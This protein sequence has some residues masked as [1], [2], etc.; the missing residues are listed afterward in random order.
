M[1]DVVKGIPLLGTAI[2][3]IID[4]SVQGLANGALT[5]VI[6]FQTIKYLAV[7]YKLQDILDGIELEE[8]EEL[9]ET[10]EEIEKELRKKKAPHV[11]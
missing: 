6:G 1:G 8:E 9:K 4:S 10:C 11:A 7:E 3:T 5:A 2:S